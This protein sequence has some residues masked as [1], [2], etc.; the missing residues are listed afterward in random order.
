MNLTVTKRRLLGAGLLFAG[1]LIFLAANLN[2]FMVAGHLSEAR[3]SLVLAL[4]LA[5][6]YCLTMRVEAPRFL[7]GLWIL[8][9]FLAL[10]YLAVYIVE[11]LAGQDAGALSEQIFW[12]NYFWCQVVYLLIFA[13]TNQFRLSVALG[14]FF[15][16]AVGTI[17]HFVLLFRGNPLQ[18]TDI[19]SL[20]TAMDVINNYVIAPDWP[21]LLDGSVLFMATCLAM[22][23]QFHRR[24]RT[25]NCVLYS[26]VLLLALGVAGSSFYKEG[27]WQE[28]GISMNFW[29]MLQGYQDNGTALSLAMEF[30]YLMP[31]K[32][33]GY[34][35]QEA[36]RI[37][38][39]SQQP[40][41][42]GPGEGF[43]G[44]NRPAA[45]GEIRSGAKG[46]DRQ[47]V[48]ELPNIIAIMN[49]SYADLSILGDFSVTFPYM[50]F[51]QSLEE[52]TIRGYAS[53]SVLGGGT[54]NTEFEFLTGLTTA[55]LPAGVMAYQQY[56]RD[57]LDS[58]ASTLTAQGYRAV[59]FHPGLPDSWNRD[60]V[61]PHLGFEAFLTEADMED[62]TYM[63]EAYVTDQSDYQEVIRL[64]EEKGDEK[65]FLFN[66][67]IQNHGGYR[68][69]TVDIPRWVSLADNAPGESYPET[70]EYL[71][72]MQA[73]DAAL[74]ALIGY[75]E[76]VEEPTLIVFFGDHQPSVEQ[77]FTEKLLG[78]SIE[79]LTLEEVQRRYKV[80]FF[81]WA[82]Y[83]IE[84]A[85]YDNISI[86][87]LST[88]ALET[89]GVELSPFQVYLR[90]LYTH[91]PMIN[92]LGYTDPAGMQ[93][94]FGETTE[95]TPW[96]DGYRI[97]QYNNLFGGKDR[98]D[99]Y[100]RVDG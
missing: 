37:L 83:D 97:V 28:S 88:L 39:A 1:L 75:F 14:S 82:N 95:E 6:C 63:R 55:F 29:N 17:N 96:I 31:E 60:Q 72:V 93:H 23:A 52:N 22:L 40:E 48:A 34:S 61:Y 27:T 24:R 86:N 76:Q 50:A 21:L 79:N 43:G 67:T 4:L 47:G 87:Y 78:K 69:N 35:A 94:H 3:L 51:Y 59:A 13:L 65:L 25:W 41:G 9:S 12:L 89:A 33:P 19:F 70:E 98:L 38:L 73:S 99:D 16:F 53:V 90:D 68:L 62:P 20:G 56:I 10:P 77:A 46:T 81:I 42:D 36:E 44:Q 57:D 32:P 18:L 2:L 71:S 66:V 64:F 45:G 5:G 30:K 100:Y 54:C 49:E 11:D 84:E 26:L 85:Y 80:P 92:A 15:C 91:V 7:N 74:E 8:L 58:M